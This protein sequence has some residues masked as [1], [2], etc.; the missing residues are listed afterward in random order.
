[1]RRLTAPIAPFLAV[2]ASAAAVPADDKVELAAKAEK[3]R[4]EK[5]ENVNQK[6]AEGTCVIYRPFK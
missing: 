4:Q 3:A 1:M 6:V 2:L 5:L